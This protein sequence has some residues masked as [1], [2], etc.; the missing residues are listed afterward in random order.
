MVLVGVKE[1]SGEHVDAYIRQ[2]CRLRMRKRNNKMPI[3]KVKD[4]AL[5]TIL[6]NITQEVGSMGPHLA[7]RSH[8]S[9][10]V[11]CLSPTVYS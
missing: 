1:G 5:W 10:V 4:L 8:V 6:C 11:M 2:Y 7:S 3:A 9:Y